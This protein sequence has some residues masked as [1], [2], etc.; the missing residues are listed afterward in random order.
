MTTIERIFEFI[1]LN[2]FFEFFGR[3]RTL[4][5]EFTTIDIKIGANTISGMKSMKKK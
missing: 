4:R 5:I 3:I 1:I 2:L